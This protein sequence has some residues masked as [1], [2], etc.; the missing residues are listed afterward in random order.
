MRKQTKKKT[1]LLLI[2]V[3][4]VLVDAPFLI[5]SFTFVDLIQPSSVLGEAAYVIRASHPKEN[6]ECTASK[7]V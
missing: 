6:P 2:I 4:I 1:N 7:H 3:I 5:S